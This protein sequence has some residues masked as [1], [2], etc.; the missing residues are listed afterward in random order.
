MNP[1]NPTPGGPHDTGWRVNRALEA[2]SRAKTTSQPV[3]PASLKATEPEIPIPFPLTKGVDPEA[4]PWALLLFLLG[5]CFS[6][7]FL[8]CAVWRWLLGEG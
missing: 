1:I 7:V 3:T 5:G 2:Y 8:V 6:G 4:L